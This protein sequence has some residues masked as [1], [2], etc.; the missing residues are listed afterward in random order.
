MNVSKFDEMC[1]LVSDRFLM[2]LLLFIR[3]AVESRSKVAPGHFVSWRLRELT[4]IQRAYASKRNIIGSAKV[5]KRTISICLIRWTRRFAWSTQAN[6]ADE[7]R[8]C[9]SMSRTPSSSPVECRRSRRRNKHFTKGDHM[10]VTI[11]KESLLI[12]ISWDSRT[13]NYA[14]LLY[15]LAYL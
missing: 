7:D 12:R 8:A 9:P 4:T 15:A 13:T 1:R 2:I 6:I 5:C 11:I 14:I 10:W 3:M